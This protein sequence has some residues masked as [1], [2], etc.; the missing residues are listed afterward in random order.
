M[1]NKCYSADNSFLN[2]GNFAFVRK[3]SNFDKT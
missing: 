3:H 1:A 2:E